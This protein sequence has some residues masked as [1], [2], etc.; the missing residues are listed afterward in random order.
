MSCNSYIPDLNIDCEQV[1]KQRAEKFWLEL[2]NKDDRKAIRLLAKQYVI[3]S[4]IMEP[5]WSMEQVTVRSSPFIITYYNPL[6]PLIKFEWKIYD[7]QLL[8]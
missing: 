6:Q 5:D 8:K 4:V 1:W 7:Y 3:E 2:K